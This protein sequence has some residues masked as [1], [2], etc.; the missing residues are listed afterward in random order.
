M[1]IFP[2]PLCDELVERTQVRVTQ[3]DARYPREQL[4]ERVVDSDGYPH[5][6]SCSLNPFSETEPDVRLSLGRRALAA[7]TGHA[8]R[9]VVPW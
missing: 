3:T 4:V 6:L 7:G 1:T 8:P 9:D 2:C 5:A